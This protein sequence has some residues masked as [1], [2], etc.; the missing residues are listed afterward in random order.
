MSIYEG[1]TEA[2]VMYLLASRYYKGK[3]YTRQANRVMLAMNPYR[4]L[5]IYTDQVVEMYRR[6]DNLPPHVFGVAKEAINFLS[7]NRSKPQSVV[8]I[9]ESGS[10]KT[11]TCKQ[12]IKVIWHDNS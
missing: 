2:Y 3:I 8:I 5:P 10:G 11:E 1:R 6:S 7:S 12:Y 4:Q 9:G